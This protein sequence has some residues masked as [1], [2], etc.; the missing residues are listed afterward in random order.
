[1]GCHELPTA[2]GQAPLDRTDSGFRR[3]ALA[4]P[5]ALAVLGEQPGFA[6]AKEVGLFGCL[7][8]E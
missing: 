2:E 3:A 4:G 1:M 8:R 6:A 7:L 5:A